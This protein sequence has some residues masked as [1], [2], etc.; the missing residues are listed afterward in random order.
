MKGGSGQ[1]PQPNK[2]GSS[3]A[4]KG[5]WNWSP[6]FMLHSSS[7]HV[8]PGKSSHQGAFSPCSR[9]S[10]EGGYTR[11]HPGSRQRPELCPRLCNNGAVLLGHPTG[12]T[13]KELEATHALLRGGTSPP[14]GRRRRGRTCP[15]PPP[16][17]VLARLCGWERGRKKSG[18]SGSSSGCQATGE[19]VG[20]RRKRSRAPPQGGTRQRG[21]RAAAAR[22]PRAR[23]AHASLQP[24]PPPLAG[25]A[26]GLRVG[27]ECSYGRSR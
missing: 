8:H 23:A 13:Q 18:V 17:Q 1:I 7:L 22:P 4:G 27:R 21:G 2:S 20:P 24:P 26:A 14:L 10:G 19:K 12:L 25:L 15:A 11:P 16:A 3:D 9:R 5:A 6:E